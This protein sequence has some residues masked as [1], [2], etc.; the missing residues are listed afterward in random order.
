MKPIQ[1]EDLLGRE[2]I[3]IDTYRI[4]GQTYNKV[5]LIIYKA[6]WVN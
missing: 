4:A 2:E 3:K 1:F 5:I 6:F